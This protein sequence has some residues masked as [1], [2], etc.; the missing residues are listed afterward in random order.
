MVLRSSIPTDRWV[1][2]ATGFNLREVRLFK[3]DNPAVTFRASTFEMFKIAC[4][5]ALAL[6]GLV[7]RVDAHGYVQELT[8]GSTKYTGY[9]PYSDP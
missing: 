3:P 6:L 2:C 1:S 9:L 8:L 4:A 5:A 7:S